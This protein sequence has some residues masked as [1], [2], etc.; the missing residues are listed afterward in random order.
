MKKASRFLKVAAIYIFSAAFFIVGIQTVY[1]NC[2]K[3][4][5][6][7]SAPPFEINIIENGMTLNI[8]GESFTITDDTLK[9]AYEF[10]SDS[11]MKNGLVNSA[12]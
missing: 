12:P 8:F 3:T 9:K 6:A 11:V 1:K 4:E 5:Y 10:C 2:S 7:E